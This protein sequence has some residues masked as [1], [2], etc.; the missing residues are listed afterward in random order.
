M[1]TEKC[2]I[3][4][5]EGH[6]NCLAVVTAETAEQALVRFYKNAEQKVSFDLFQEN[7]KA[8]ETAIFPVWMN[9]F[10]ES[11]VKDVWK[12]RIIPEKG[13]PAPEVTE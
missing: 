9:S 2:F 7:H 12:N 8:V 5:G 1:P 10:D 3:I 11:F 13:E 6:D 4:F